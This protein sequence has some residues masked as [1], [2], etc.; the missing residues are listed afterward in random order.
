[1]G[2]MNEGAL[3]HPAGRPSSRGSSEQLRAPRAPRVLTSWTGL[4]QKQLQPVFGVVG[5]SEGRALGRARGTRCILDVGS[6]HSREISASGRHWRRGQLVSMG[7]MCAAHD[8]ERDRSVTRRAL[9]SSQLLVAFSFSRLLRS[10]LNLSSQP[11]PHRWPWYRPR[12]LKL[13]DPSLGGSDSSLR[14]PEVLPRSRA[15]AAVA[16]GQRLFQEYSPRS[17]A[18]VARPSSLPCAQNRLSVA[19]KYPTQ[20]SSPL[21][22]FTA[23]FLCIGE[24]PPPQRAPNSWMAGVIRSPRS[25]TPI[26]TSA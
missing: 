23:L 15:R 2:W 22:R 8:R 5:R 11:C 13:G 26:R 3:A 17:R 7:P 18:G 21:P 24:H 16:A 14:E 12:L 19:H 25:P 6:T 1:V 10:M 4:A 20:Y 9:S